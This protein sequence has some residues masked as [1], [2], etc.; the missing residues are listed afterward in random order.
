MG[1]KKYF[2]KSGSMRWHSRKGGGDSVDKKTAALLHPTPWPV[3]PVSRTSMRWPG[4]VGQPRPFNFSDDSPG[5]AALHGTG[6]WLDGN[7]ANT[8][9]GSG[10]HARRK[11]EKK[12][13]RCVQTRCLRCAR[14]SATDGC[15]VTRCGPS[16]RSHSNA[17]TSSTKHQH[18]IKQAGSPSDFRVEVVSLTRD[19]W[20]AR[21]RRFQVAPT[22]TPRSRIRTVQ[23]RPVRMASTTP[24]CDRGEWERKIFPR[25]SKAHPPKI[26]KNNRKH[27][28]MGCPTYPLAPCQ[29]PPRPCRARTTVPCRL[30]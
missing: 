5:L 30:D 10:G 3:T 24:R 19:A 6:N 20:R 14:C 8:L 11:K 17:G 28:S 26:P 13:K 15:Q 18:N 9:E 25:V 4:R 7:N 16:S 21:A 29:G 1:G 23:H 27:G 12:E 2:S 22:P